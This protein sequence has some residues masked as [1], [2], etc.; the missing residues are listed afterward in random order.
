[1]NSLSETR[2]N[3]EEFKEF[4]WSHGWTQKS[5][6]EELGLSYSAMSQ[7]IRKG[8]PMP[9]YMVIGIAH[10]TGMTPDQICACLL[11]GV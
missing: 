3:Y 1:M 10:R 6:A 11:G 5:L 9:G 2:V 4:L 8:N 7:H